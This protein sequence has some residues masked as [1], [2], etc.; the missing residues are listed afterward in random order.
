MSQKNQPWLW[1]N[2]AG[3]LTQNYLAGYKSGLYEKKLT[4]VGIFDTLRIDWKQLALGVNCLLKWSGMWHSKCNSLK[5]EA[6]TLMFTCLKILFKC[7]CF[8]LLLLWFCVWLCVCYTCPSL[9]HKCFVRV[10]VEW[11]H[12]KSWSAGVKNMVN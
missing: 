6:T 8:C 11:Q 10:V 3:G 9:H 7:S 12:F 4:F 2:N 5:V 1:K